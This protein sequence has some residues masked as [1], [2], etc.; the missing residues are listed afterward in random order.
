MEQYGELLQAYEPEIE[1]MYEAFTNF[2]NNPTMTK[3]KDV[4]NYSVYMTKTYCLLSRECRYLVAMVEKDTNDIGIGE[5]LKSLR[6][7]S[8][9]TRTLSD[10]YQLKSHSYNPHS[11][12]P[13]NCV[14]NRIS[15]TDRSSTYDC[16]DFPIKVTLLYTKDH[17]HE[18]Q[19]KGTVIAALETYQTIITII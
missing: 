8:F 5:E 16:P 15:T 13:L 11:K 6:W 7:A 10:N 2:Y 9:Q 4:E 3:T 19:P 1:N 18:Y 12:G 14:I 17:Q